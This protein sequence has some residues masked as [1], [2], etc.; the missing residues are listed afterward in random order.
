MKDRIIRDTAASNKK[1]TSVIPWRKKQCCDSKFK[2]NETAHQ[3]LTTIITNTDND[4]KKPKLIAKVF[5]IERKQTEN[6]PYDQ[7]TVTSIRNDSS[8]TIEHQ[9]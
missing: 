4:D 1:I 7:Q 3:L 6:H 2:L 8:D 9:R 5:A